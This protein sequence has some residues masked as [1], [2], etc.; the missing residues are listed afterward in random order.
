MK[1][2]HPIGI[3][4]PSDEA[5]ERFILVPCRKCPACLKNSQMEWVQRL[6]DEVAH[7]LQSFFITLT[8]DPQFLPIHYFDPYHPAEEYHF[9]RF[10]DI[11]STKYPFGA[12]FGNPCVSKKD[13]QNFF[14]RLRLR[15]SDESIRYYAISEYGPLNRRPHYHIMLFLQEPLNH[16][17]IDDCWPYGFTDIRSVQFQRIAYVA[18]HHLRPK[19]H[20]VN[21][22]SSFLPPTDFCFIVPTFRLMSKGIGK[23]HLSDSFIAHYLNGGQPFRWINGKKSPLPSYYKRKLKEAGY[24]FIP[25]DDQLDRS[26]FI[27]ELFE[28]FPDHDIDEIH[29]MYDFI[30]LQN[31]KRNV[32]K[33]KCK[34]L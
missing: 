8:Y 31:E 4:D 7:S 15:Y 10:G 30:V 29:Q 1:C 18:K 23:A 26:Q 12:D 19:D 13:L 24:Q 5:G 17:D 28:Y 33:S 32:Q 34:F 14:K 2:F 25:Q 22:Y 20:D 3:P 16:A 21:E 11:D 27:E 6:N 9:V